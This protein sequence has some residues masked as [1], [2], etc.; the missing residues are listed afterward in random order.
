MRRLNHTK[1]IKNRM[2][3]LGSQSYKISKKIHIK[4]INFSD[5]WQL[6]SLFV[7]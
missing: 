2:K 6:K 1:D 3:I 7:S 4:D 5:N